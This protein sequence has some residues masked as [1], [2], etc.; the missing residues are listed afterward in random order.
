[1]NTLLRH[2]QPNIQL[3]YQP[4]P[5]PPREAIA[6][7]KGGDAGISNYLYTVKHFSPERDCFFFQPIA[8]KKPGLVE[9]KVLAS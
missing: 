8:M 2:Y 5:Q 3:Q 7:G 9:V 4:P 1:M 6:F